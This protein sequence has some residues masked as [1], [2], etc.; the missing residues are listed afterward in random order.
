MP[1]LHYPGH[2]ND[3][4]SYLRLHV[5]TDHQWS[6]GRDNLTVIK[7]AIDGGATTIQLRNKTAS[8]SVLIEEGLA[9]RTLTK[10]RGVLLIVNDRVDVAL[11]IDADGAH[12]GQDDMPAPLARKL[13]GSHRILGVSVSNSAEAQA[14]IAADADYLGVSPIF[15]TL[16]KTDTGPATG[17][18]LLTELAAQHKIPLVAIGGI[19]VEN[20]TEIIQAGAAGIAVITAVVYAKDITAA[21][22]QLCQA[23]KRGIA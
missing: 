6:R 23:I 8:T 16:T 2:A 11:A 4:A 1:L 17:I 5:L 3:L 14:A 9:L 10:E 21:T 12:V 15:S 18:Q 13:L 22:R 20:T 7:A 19:N